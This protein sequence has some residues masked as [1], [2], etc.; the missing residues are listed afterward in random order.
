MRQSVTG[1]AAE[2]SNFDAA[3]LLQDR[4]GYYAFWHKQRPAEFVSR[5]QNCARERGASSPLGVGRQVLAAGGFPRF[6]VNCAIGVVV[7]SCWEG[8]ARNEF[9]ARHT[10]RP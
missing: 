7:L 8:L 10:N 5:F 1:H 3:D 9:R 4:R 2:R 6:Q